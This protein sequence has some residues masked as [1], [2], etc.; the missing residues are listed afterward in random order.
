MAIIF[1]SG[2]KFSYS[3]TKK[4]I[5]SIRLRLKSNHSFIVSC[6]YLTP[7]IVVTRFIQKNKD[8]IVTHSHKIPRKSQ[9]KNLKKLSI[10]GQEY[11]LVFINTSHDSVVI[12]PE[13]Q[14]IYA[15]ISK[16]SPHH[17]KRILET[18][19]RPF[20]LSLINQELSLLKKQY[21]FDYNHVTVR[22]QSSRYGSCSSRS[23]LNFNWQI[24]FFPEDKFRHILLHELTHLQIKNHSKF[25]W[26]QLTTYDPNCHNNNL[27]LKKQGTKLFLF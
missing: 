16:N 20:A 23:N 2:Q 7:N 12:Y 18:K 22:N 19:I 9:I 27:W 25:F 14:K 11:Q 4:A 1:L 8:W 3:I 6:P 15:N 26:N 17:I 13:S 24:I 10:L 5:R 21:G